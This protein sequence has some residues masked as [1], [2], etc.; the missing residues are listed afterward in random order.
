MLVL[1]TFA[2]LVGCCGDDSGSGGCDPDNSGN[3]CKYVKPTP[4][5]VTRI[6][7]GVLLVDY[8]HEGSTNALCNQSYSIGVSPK[9]AG[10]PRSDLIVKCQENMYDKP[11]GAPSAAPSSNG[12]DDGF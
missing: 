8:G 3:D 9:T 6:G 10:D 11:Q 12:Y 5:H 1:V 4:E 2:L 7:R